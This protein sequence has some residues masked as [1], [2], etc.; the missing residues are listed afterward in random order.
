MKLELKKKEALKSFESHPNLLIFYRTVHIK[1]EAI[2]LSFKAV[3]GGFVDP[4]EG[5]FAVAKSV[6][7]TIGDAV[8]VAP[9]IGNLIQQT[10]KWTICKGL[11]KIDKSRQNNIAK[12]AS[13]LVTLSE[14]T[15]YAESIAR[16]LTE[17]YAEQLQL[18]MTPEEEHSKSK[19]SQGKQKMEKTLFK[20]QIA[21]GSKQLAAFAVLAMVDKLYDAQ[22][23]EGQDLEK[24]LLSV[25]IPKSSLSGFEK[26]KSKIKHFWEKLCKEVGIEALKTKSG[27]SW[28]P[29]EV[30]TKP[31]IRTDKNE[32]YDGK[33]MDSKQFGWRLGTLEEANLMS[34]KQNLSPHF[35]ANILQIQVVAPPNDNLLT[36]GAH[37]SFI[38]EHEK[39]ARTKLEKEIVE[40]RSERMKLE[41]QIKELKDSKEREKLKLEER[42]RALKE[43]KDRDKQKIQELQESKEREKL[44]SEEKFQALTESKERSKQEMKEIKIM[45]QRLSDTQHQ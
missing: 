26:I 19:L 30:F 14:V 34:L 13:D 21:P 24:I 23:F 35:H 38:L 42:F 17:R 2:F 12:N 7:D 20:K 36:T 27:K 41:Q 25:L 1:L 44:K 28:H 45:I 4:V 32:Y 16:K 3:A 15:K 29:D 33:E 31:G 9:I 37:F 22:T 8:T 6:F 10:L 40:E 39:E 11:S 43:S 18:L 5:N